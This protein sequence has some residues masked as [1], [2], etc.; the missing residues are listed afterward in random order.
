MYTSTELIFSKPVKTSDT[1]ADA[2]FKR[3][4][5]DTLVISVSF[6]ISESV[7]NAFAISFKVSLGSSTNSSSLSTNSISKLSASVSNA[8]LAFLLSI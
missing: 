8:S 1:P 3:S 2:A 7:T 5:G 6:S 4:I